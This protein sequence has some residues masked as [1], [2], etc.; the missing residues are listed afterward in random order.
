MSARWWKAPETA[1]LDRRLQTMRPALFRLWFNL[2]CVSSWSGGRLPSIEDA[3]FLLRMSPA[4]FARG[5]EALEGLGLLSRLGD[6]IML[7]AAAGGA[8]EGEEDGR[9]RPGPM[10]AAERTRRWREARR[11]ARDAARDGDCDAR[12]VTV[13]PLEE[14][15]KEKETNSPRVTRE[16]RDDFF[17]R[18]WSAFPSR[19]GDNPKAPA[20]A[21]WRKALAGGA[22]PEE[23]IA[24][25]RRY[26]ESTRDR[27]RR[28]ICSAV[29]WLS[30]ERWRSDKPA[31]AAVDPQGVW[32]AA[33]APE[34]AAWAE[35]WRATKGKTPPIDSKGGWRFP[36]KAPPVD[37]DP[38][39]ALEG[40][41]AKGAKWPRS[42][43]V[44][45][46]ETW[47]RNPSD[48]PGGWWPPDHASCMFPRWIL[49]ELGVA[50]A[51]RL[52]AAE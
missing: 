17:E 27:E 49:E 8:P 29:R 39:I 47:K 28:F 22:E 25:A 18:F 52:E 32:I 19:D 46:V 2:N 3:A 4:T 31:P 37:D 10:T 5:L 16:E 11:D 23:L 48:W 30:E 13:T 35:H 36:S 50:P 24:A 42:K 51:Q 14:E 7:H 33:D 38:L 34:W 21:A 43:I 26:A 40:G 20:L 12:D 6:E 44:S 41:L 9:A 1:F 45:M 15:K